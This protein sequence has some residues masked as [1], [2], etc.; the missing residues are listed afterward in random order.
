MSDNIDKPIKLSHSKIKF[1][2]LKK[3]ENIVTIIGT[4]LELNGILATRNICRPDTEKKPCE[5]TA[6]I[7]ENY[8]SPENLLC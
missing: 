1:Q 3:N 5:S 7:L 2:T 4:V 8:S 6:E